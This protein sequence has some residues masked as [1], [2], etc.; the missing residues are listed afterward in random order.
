MF[1]FFK[2]KI[3]TTIQTI[4]F[5]SSNSGYPMHQ[6][7]NRSIRDILLIP[8]NLSICQFLMFANCLIICININRNKKSH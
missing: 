5:I 6:I 4:R 3:S 8:I 1:I 2:N 7:I